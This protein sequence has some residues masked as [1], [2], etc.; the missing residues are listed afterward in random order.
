MDSLIVVRIGNRRDMN[1]DIDE[2][3]CIVIQKEGS[4]V[5]KRGVGLA[6]S[7]DP[8][9]AD[10][11]V[12]S[13]EVGG[14]A[15]GN[16]GG[17]AMVTRRKSKA[18]SA[19][20]ASPQLAKTAKVFA[21]SSEL[22]RKRKAEQSMADQIAALREMVL[23]LIKGQE[24]QRLLYEKQAAELGA[25]NKALREEAEK[26]GRTL[27]LLEALSEKSVR[28][29]TYSEAAKTGLQQIAKSQ[30]ITVFPS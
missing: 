5:G 10:A 19:A 3:D 21:S 26:H 6:G 4:E 11:G 22:E 13:T 24:E 17:W 23:Q 25:V 8:A 16:R 18:A 1:T 29:P 14:G 9:G 15:E 12:P 27:A 28:T 20:S 30:K 7:K 2:S